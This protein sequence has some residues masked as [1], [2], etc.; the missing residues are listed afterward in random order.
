MPVEEF[1]ALNPGFS[2]P[3]I[4]ASVTPRIVLPADKVDLFH[5]NLEK[6]DAAALV[7]WKTYHPK[8]GETFESIAKK[9]GMSL[10]Q[11]KEVNGIAPR[12]RTVP[13]LLVVPSSPAAV[14]TRK[15]PLM[16]APPIPIVT[17]RIYHTGEVGR[18]ADLDRE[19]LRRRAGRHE[20]LERGVRFAPGV[21]VAVEVRA[22]VKK[23]KRAKGKGKT[24]KQARR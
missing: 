20:A 2:R 3:I 18:D 12:T 8:K 13:N 14:E 4:R 7:S 1:I 6:Y 11:L 21:K 17:R 19:A 15:L 24:Y 22:P 10:G 9:V 5:D 23:T 16:Y